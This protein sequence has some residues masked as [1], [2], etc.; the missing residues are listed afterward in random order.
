[1][2]VT[3]KIALGLLASAA[4]AFTAYAAVTVDEDGYGFVG[5]GDVQLAYD[6]NNAEL[7][8]NAASLTFSFTSIVEATWQCEWWTGP[9]HNIKHHVNTKTSTS[10]IA[11]SIGFDARKNKQGQITGFN[12]N[13]FDGTTETT[14]GDAIGDCPGEGAGKTLVA[15]SLLTTTL[16][17][18]SLMVNHT[19]LGSRQLT[20]SQ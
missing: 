17:E 8:A 4:T 5:K 18:G 6:W 19:G 13:G 15:G 20:I 10:G 7:Q 12:L 9:D 14:S 3:S 1:M 11:A 2:N 16:D